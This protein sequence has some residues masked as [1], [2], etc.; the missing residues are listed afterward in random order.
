M[1]V[2]EEVSKVVPLWHVALSMALTGRHFEEVYKNPQRCGHEAPKYGRE[3]T[4]QAP[5]LIKGEKVVATKSYRSALKSN[6]GGTWK[7]INTHQEP[8]ICSSKQVCVCVWS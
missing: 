7:S 8:L 3:V 2:F 6:K 5:K 1:G 4:G